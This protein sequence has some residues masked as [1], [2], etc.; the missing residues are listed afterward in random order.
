MNPVSFGG[1]GRA[2]HSAAADGVPAGASRGSDPMASGI[3]GH[4]G[5]FSCSLL[6]V[7]E[8]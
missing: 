3:I 8:V 1:R 5:L 7:P 6:P 2:G 4:A